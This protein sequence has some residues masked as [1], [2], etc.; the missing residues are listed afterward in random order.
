[1]ALTEDNP[2]A[3]PDSDF[4]GYLQ[5]GSS[6]SINDVGIRTVSQSYVNDSGEMELPRVKTPHPIF[7]DLLLESATITQQEGGYEQLDVTYKG[8]SGESFSTETTPGGNESLYP[9]VNTLTRSLNQE[10]LDTHPNFSGSATSIVADACGNDGSV[11]N[12]EIIIRDEGGA[13]VKISDLS[14]EPNLAG[15]TSYLA[16]GQEF[17]IRYAS[18]TIPSITNVGRIVSAPTGA[19]PVSGNFNWLLSAINFTQ[20]GDI[21]EVTENYLLS[22]VNGWAQSIYNYTL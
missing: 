7:T 22:G 2:N 4:N 17:T 19:P 1:M 16:P 10:P 11:E 12:K 3:V 9:V 15:A 18:D 20:E 21:F 6:D 13:F 8:K 14:F 5:P